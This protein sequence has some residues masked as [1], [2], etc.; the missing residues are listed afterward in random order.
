VEQLRFDAALEAQRKAGKPER[1]IILKA[2][3]IGFSTWTQTKLLQRATQWPDQEC[4]TVAQD[5]E[6]AGKLFRMASLMYQLLPTDPE[7]GIKPALKNTRRD[8]EMVF[9]EPSAFKR[10]HSEL[11]MNSRY[12]V[13]TAGEF[14]A[15]RGGTY[16]QVHCS[17]V[18]QWQDIEEKLMGVL[19]GVP[20]EPDT[21]VVLE[22]T[23]RHE[24]LQG[25]VG[26]RGAGP[27]GVHRVLLG[28][29]RGADL[30]ASVRAATQ[31]RRTS[32]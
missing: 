1:A 14:N 3:Q 5:T 4:F 19:E 2:R 12:L 32:S 31:R 24:H 13:D 29:V 25:S 15:G 11:G 7:L 26:R 30:H 20:D 18:A 8:R 6:T 23:A 9:G 28:L 16:S 21:M 10:Q 17:E 27:I 22:S